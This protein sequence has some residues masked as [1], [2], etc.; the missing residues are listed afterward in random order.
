MRTTGGKSSKLDF[1]PTAPKK[2]IRFEGELSPISI[3]SLV[4]M[5]WNG[6]KYF[7]LIKVLIWEIGVSISCIYHH[8]LRVDHLRRDRE[9]RGSHHST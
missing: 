8:V 5:L 1:P 2:V 7:D 9:K 3:H 4:L 6:C